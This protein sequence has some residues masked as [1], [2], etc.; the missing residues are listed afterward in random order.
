MRRLVSEYAAATGLA[1]GLLGI[2]WSFDL[3]VEFRLIASLMI[4]TV[5]AVFVAVRY[6]QSRTLEYTILALKKTLSI[7]DA[8]GQRATLTREST[9]IAGTEGLS[10]IWFRNIGA[11]GRIENVQSTVTI[12]GNLIEGE[13]K[14]FDDMGLTHIRRSLTRPLKKGEQI[15]STVTYDVV[16]SFSNSRESFGHIVNFKTDKLVMIVRLPEQRPSQTAELFEVFGGTKRVLLAQFA[17]QSTNL[18]F[19]RDNPHLGATYELTWMW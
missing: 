10:E 9:E 16:D 7:H 3:A 12:D 8:G 2:I 1:V 19:E 11:T 6:V 4:F 13:V 15:Q 14:V 5:A 17:E 18:T